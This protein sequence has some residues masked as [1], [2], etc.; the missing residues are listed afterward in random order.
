[1]KICFATNNPNKLKEIRQLLGDQFDIQSLEDIGCREELPEN[2]QT[3]ESNSEEKARYVYDHYQVDCF[4]DDTG[5][6][7]SALDG[8]PGVYS[9]RYAGPQRKSEDNIQRLLE[10]LKG[11]EDRT[12]Q[13]RTLITLIL[14]GQVHQFEGIVKG[15]II[16][17]QV[18]TAGFGYDPVFKPEGHAQTFAEMDMETKNKISHRGRAVQKLVEFL[19]KRS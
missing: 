8:A 9:A 4:A 12:A 3:L 14:S 15:K 11:K 13:F 2:Q 1:M 10:A 7:V 18:G 17:D 16:T 19:K 6:E 5:L